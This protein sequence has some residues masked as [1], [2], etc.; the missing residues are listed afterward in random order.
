M[1]SNVSV[2]TRESVHLIPSSSTASLALVLPESKDISHVFT[3]ETLLYLNRAHGADNGYIPCIAEN[4][5]GKAKDHAML[6]ISCK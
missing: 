5:V 2:E 3:R 1:H 4:I 6:R